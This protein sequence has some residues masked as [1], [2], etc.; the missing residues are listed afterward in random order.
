M[1]DGL[2]ASRSRWPNKSGASALTADADLADVSGMIDEHAFH[3]LY[4]RTA[5]SLRAYAARVLGSVTYA[6]DIVQESFLRLVRSPPATDDPR[7]LRAILF[8]IASRLII[9]HW[10]RGRHER[11]ASGR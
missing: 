10:R 8:R 7:Q 6:D 1:G 3:D 4:R 5:P 9:D 2:V 11:A